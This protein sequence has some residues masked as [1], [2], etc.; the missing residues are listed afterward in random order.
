MLGVAVLSIFTRSGGYGSP[1]TFTDGLVVA[2]WSAQRS[3]AW[4]RSWRSPLRPG[5]GAAG[6]SV[7]EPEGAPQLEAA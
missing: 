7:E 2:T 3:W 5:G 1:E 6:V 4:A